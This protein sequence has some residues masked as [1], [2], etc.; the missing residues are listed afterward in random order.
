MVNIIFRFLSYRFSAVVVL[1]SRFRCVV[2]DI[3]RCGAYVE[4]RGGSQEPALPPPP[5]P[6]LPRSDVLSASVTCPC[7]WL[8]P[9]VLSSS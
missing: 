4:G 8:R 9:S 2:D 6:P 3:F 7:L 1:S 5:P